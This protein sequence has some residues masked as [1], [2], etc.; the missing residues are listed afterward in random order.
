MSVQSTERDEYG[1]T[2]VVE[3]EDA[4]YVSGHYIF[5]NGDKGLFRHRK[6]PVGDT[7]PWFAKEPWRYLKE[8]YDLE[9]DLKTSE[10][11]GNLLERK[12]IDFCYLLHALKS[13]DQRYTAIKLMVGVLA[14]I[15]KETEASPFS[16]IPQFQYR[17]LVGDH[18]LN[19]NQ[20][21]AMVPGLIA[22]VDYAT[23]RAKHV[24]AEI[25]DNEIDAAIQSEIVSNPEQ[26]E[27]TKE[28]PAMKNWFVGQVMKKYQGK[29]DAA[30]VK[31]RLDT[32]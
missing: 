19:Y 11:L 16:L 26:W 6:S 1:R 30:R 31:Q 8:Q 14:Q 24:F 18:T 32:F 29:I 20:M 2:V 13:N 17:F 7:T 15:A 3:H 21:K 22:G 12:W 28:K 10:A 27:K 5:P 4:D 23:E 25:S 9:I